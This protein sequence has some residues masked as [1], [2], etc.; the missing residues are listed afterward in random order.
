MNCCEHRIKRLRNPARRLGIKLMTIFF[1][2][3]YKRQEFF[4]VWLVVN[5]IWKGNTPFVDFNFR[6][7]FCNCFIGKQH[8]FFNKLMG[9]LALLYQNAYGFTFFIELKTN[10]LGGKINSA[11]LK[12]LLSKPLCKIIKN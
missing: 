2:E 8:K 5:S 11:I 4:G 9:F 7:I 3:I 10:F 1:C 12:S 6:N